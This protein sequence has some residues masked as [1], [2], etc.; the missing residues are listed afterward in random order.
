MRKTKIIATIGPSS[1]SNEMI[2]K[3]ILKGVDLFRLNFSHGDHETHLQTIKKIRNISAKLR[4]YTAI[5]QDLG[6]PKIR[7][8]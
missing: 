8:L 5:L 6:G 3:L 2:E 1:S 4:K 7:L